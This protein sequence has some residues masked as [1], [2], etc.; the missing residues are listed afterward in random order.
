MESTDLHNYAD[1][2]TFHVCDVNLETLVKR[3]EH[4]SMLAKK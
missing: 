4:D 2:T 3:L 1:V